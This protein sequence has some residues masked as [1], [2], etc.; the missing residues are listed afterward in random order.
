VIGGALV[1]FDLAGPAAQCCSYMGHRGIERAGGP[2]FVRTA[3]Y[4]RRA[5]NQVAA[6]HPISTTTAV[7]L[8]HEGLST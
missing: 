8:A 3:G 1:S 2:T 6:G 7:P 5:T 4:R